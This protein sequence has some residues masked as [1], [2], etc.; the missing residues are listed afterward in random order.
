MPR[1]IHLDIPEE[2]NYTAEIECDC[3]DVEVI[4]DQQKNAIVKGRGRIDVFLNGKYFS[5]FSGCVVVYAEDLSL[6][7]EPGKTIIGFG[8]FDVAKSLKIDQK[9]NQMI[10]NYLKSKYPIRMES[11][12]SH[13]IDR[14]RGL[15]V[16][17]DGGTC[18]ITN[19]YGGTHTAKSSSNN[20]EITGSFGSE[21]TV[22][23]SCFDFSGVT[24]SSTID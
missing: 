21:V 7:S 11:I 19:P 9:T 14:T 4:Y 22:G 24:L 15:F 2:Y 1:R 23:G 16:A 12:T 18:V 17:S 10:L 3:D 5:S 6:T 8:K 20:I 13:T